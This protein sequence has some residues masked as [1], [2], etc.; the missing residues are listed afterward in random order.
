[1]GDGCGA[2]RSS[3]PGRRSG[4]R[5]RCGERRRRHRRGWSRPTR[6]AGP[7]SEAIAGP[8]LEFSS[9]G[10]AAI[11][12]AVQNEQLHGQSRA[13]LGSSTPPGRWQAQAVRGAQAVL[14]TAF[15]RSGT[16][17]LLTGTAP[18]PRACCATVSIRRRSGGASHALVT[19]LTGTTDGGLVAL[20]N[21]AL[22]A[23]I[24]TQRGLWVAQSDR[25]GTFAT[26][27]VSQLQLRPA[28]RPT[29]TRLR[30][31]A[32][33]ERSR[34]RS[35]GRPGR[36]R[37]TGSF[38]PPGRRGP[39]PR[40]RTW[41]CA[42]A[43]ADTASTSSALAP[44]NQGATL[45]W[46]ESWYDA[47]G[48]PLGREVARCRRRGVVARSPRPFELASDLAFAGNR[49]GDQVIACDGV[50]GDGD[51]RR[52][53]R[54]AAGGRALRRPALRSAPS[55]RS[56][57]VA[58]AISAHGEALVGWIA[59]GDVRGGCA[60]ASRAQV[61]A[62]QNGRGRRRRQRRSDARVRPRARR[63]RGVDAGN[64]VAG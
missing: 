1:M 17:W 64:R 30:S 29:S 53:R 13:L 36:A 31:R 48:V 4:A 41:R 61:R 9:A 33:V 16:L 39:R 40:I 55:T 58:A 15:S 21:G 28:H 14:G 38:T 34:G 11:A 37:R 3:S 27:S 10:A 57:A 7:E 42:G 56:Q 35:P 46:V 24:A 47:R 59:D 60:P 50:L 32:A 8:Q 5:G 12:F 19:G 62:G 26:G 22:M 6:I 23:A 20:P 45:A 54:R 49:A 51:L 18:S 25:H 2:G 52:C 63:A 44:A 43:R